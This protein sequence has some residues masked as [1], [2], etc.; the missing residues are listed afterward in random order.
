MIPLDRKPPGMDIALFDRVLLDR[1]AAAPVIPDGA[2][3]LLRDLTAGLHRA[4]AP[5]EPT[6]MAVGAALG[7]SL[8]LLNGIGDDFRSLSALIESPDGIG[9]VA[10]LTQARQGTLGLTGNAQRTLSGLTALD[11]EGTAMAALLAALSRVIGE[12]TALA[13]NAKVQAAQIRST[14]DDFTV[15]TQ[16]ID[17]LHRLANGTTQRA[18]D[19]LSGLRTAIGAACAAAAGFHRDNRGDLD[20]IGNR[21]KASLDELTARR[22]AARDAARRFAARAAEIG[23]RITRCIL[24]LQVGDVT[25]QRV[26]HI[27]HALDLMRVMIGDAAPASVPGDSAWLTTIPPARRPALLAAVCELQ[28]RQCAEASRDFTAQMGSLKGNLA[29]LA[30]D[31]EAIAAEARRMF[32]DAEASD[33]SFIHDV[34]AGVDRAILL[35]DRYCGADDAIRTQIVQVSAGFAAM[36]RDVAAIHSIDTD[37]RLMGLNTTLKCAR[38]GEAGKALGVVA[39]ELRA[40]SRRTEEHSKGIAVA[41]E[42]AAAHAADLDQRSA[43]NHSAATELASGMMGSMAALRKLEAEQQKTL[44]TLT[45]ACQQASTRLDGAA[46]RLIIDGDLDAFSRSLTG[47]LAP[48]A[49]LL[50]DA[51]RADGIEDDLTRLFKDR[52]TADSERRVHGGAALGWVGGGVVAR[53]E[54]D[55]GEIDFFF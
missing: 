8:T 21:L 49:G 22:N 15:F 9:A 30:Q 32:G 19:R 16:E 28:T 38:L 42:S 53:P 18:A 4:A 7:E 37:M 52:Y 50:A 17:R 44:G 36:T 14:T 13:T 3:V 47:R 27:G 10:A 31:A 20:D 48:L 29:A 25:N 54:P 26:E 51:A 46:G 41:I 12:I 24:D 55:G 43:T 2:A 39:Q 6:L 40:C 11:A 35:L 33:R 34:A 23:T 1:P 5:I 45:R